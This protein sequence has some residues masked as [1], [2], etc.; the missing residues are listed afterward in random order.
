MKMQTVIAMAVVATIVAMTEASLVLPYSGLDC[1]YWCKDNYDKHYCCGPPGRTYPP[2]TERSGKCPPVR[3]TC[4]G[5]RSRLPK[6]CPHD[7]ACDF[8]SKCCYDACL[9]HH[10]CK[11][12]DFY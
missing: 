12:P 11:T 6:L 2:Y 10:V 5:V 9:E 8:P 3:A 7:G 4:T 1:K